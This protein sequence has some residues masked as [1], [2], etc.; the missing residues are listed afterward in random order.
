MKTAGLIFILALLL[1]NGCSKDSLNSNNSNNNT[2]TEWLIP[3][4]QVL[5]GGPGKDGIPALQNPVFISANEA[6]YL[7]DNDLVLGFVDGE[8]ARAY[9]H[10][11]LDWHEIVNDDINNESVAVIYCPLTGTGIGWDRVVKGKK[12]TFGVSGLLY[13]S[14]IIPYDRDTDSNWSQLLLQSVNGT[15][16]GAIANTYNPC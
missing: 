6:T 12:T 2:S 13:N 4:N 14:N 1:I 11:I 16:S 9:P 3:R 5:D 8:D 15:L 7:S 10:S